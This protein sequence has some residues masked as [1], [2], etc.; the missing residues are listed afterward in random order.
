METQVKVI[1]AFMKQ[2]KQLQ[3]L[4]HRTG[5]ADVMGSS[6]FEAFF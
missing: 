5:I 2:L 3:R 6:P 1:L 4:Q